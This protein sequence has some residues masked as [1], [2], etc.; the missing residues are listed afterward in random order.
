MNHLKLDSP[1]A[2]YVAGYLICMYVAL[3]VIV[4]FN[5]TGAEDNHSTEQGRY[6]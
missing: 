4:I 5:P 3:L 2:S 6:G 1:L